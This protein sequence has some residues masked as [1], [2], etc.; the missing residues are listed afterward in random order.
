MW[1][2]PSYIICGTLSPMPLECVSSSPWGRG[3][4]NSAVVPIGLPDLQNP[5]KPTFCPSALARAH[6]HEPPGTQHAAGAPRGVGQHGEPPLHP[7]A[8]GASTPTAARDQ[9]AA[10]RRSRGRLATGRHMS[11]CQVP[12][13]PVTSHKQRETTGLR[14]RGG[15]RGRSSRG[16]RPSRGRRGGGGSAAPLDPPGTCDAAVGS[17][18]DGVGGGG[19]Q[20]RTPAPDRSTWK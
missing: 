20:Q 6:A 11:P 2:P 3:Q 8:R 13:I 10:T 15:T 4:E 9:P 18:R 5:K 7:H 14:V 1:D 19:L 12:T 17:G 16:T